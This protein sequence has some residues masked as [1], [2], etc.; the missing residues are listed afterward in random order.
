MKNIEF[1]FIK[2]HQIILVCAWCSSSSYPTLLTD[3]YYSHG[4]CNLHKQQILL[5][6]GI[7]YGL[8]IEKGGDHS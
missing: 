3:Q 1:P 8:H 7:H 2:K 4:I 5:S 6:S